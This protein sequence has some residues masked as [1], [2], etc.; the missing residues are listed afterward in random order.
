MEVAAISN[1]CRVSHLIST[2]KAQRSKRI[3]LEDWF[4]SIMFVRLANKS[5]RVATKISS[6]T[7]GSIEM[8]IRATVS[9]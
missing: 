7:G 6:H 3:G 5:V 8:S 1:G 4:G 2:L 9:R